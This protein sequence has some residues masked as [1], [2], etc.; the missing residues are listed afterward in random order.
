MS[1]RLLIKEPPSIRYFSSQLPSIQKD[2]SNYVDS[3][4]QDIKKA[5]NITEEFNFDL[6]TANTGDLLI[7]GRI[8]AKLDNDNPSEKLIGHKAQIQL[9]SKFSRPYLDFE[10]K[11]NETYYY[12]GQIVVVLG[13]FQ[14]SVFVAKQIYSNCR[15]A[16]P[17]EI[18]TL[19]NTKITVAAG[20]YFKENLSEVQDFAEG[21]L[22]NK[23]DLAIFLGPFIPADCKLLYAKECNRTGE[24]LTKE[25]LTILSN[26]H[27]NCVFVSSAEDS[28]A[29]PVLPTK[30]FMPSTDN[31]SVTMDPVFIEY[32]DLDLFLTSY[33]SYKLIANNFEGKKTVNGAEVGSRITTILTEFANQQSI[34]PGIDEQVQQSF[35]SHFRPVRPPHV[36]VVPGQPNATVSVDDDVTT[37]LI[38]PAIRRSFAMIRVKDGK[39]NSE[40]MKFK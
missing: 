38:N 36:F 7:Y 23:P 15:V 33:Q 17:H 37:I 32:G 2:L 30:A 3:M 31:Y 19:F 22:E 29:D 35:I 16:K 27:K 18:S 9:T 26:N 10:A 24:D 12:R 11:L 25:V 34:C 8:Y 28:I 20:P 6:E 39:V 13:T 1:A 40:I 4:A 21:V 5:N 14:N